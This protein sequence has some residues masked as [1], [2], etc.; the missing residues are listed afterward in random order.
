MPT[1]IVPLNGLQGTICLR[2]QNSLATTPPPLQEGCPSAAAAAAAITTLMPMDIAT[3]PKTA[4]ARSPITSMATKVNDITTSRK[5]NNK[6]TGD[7]VVTVV[8]EARIVKGIHVFS[9]FLN[10]NK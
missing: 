9:F 8:K 6:K 3:V 5:K 2:N 10:G 7:L 4:Q 1:I